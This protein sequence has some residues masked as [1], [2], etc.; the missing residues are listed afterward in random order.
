MKR[1]PVSAPEYNKRCAPPAAVFVAFHWIEC[2]PAASVT[3]TVADSELVPPALC[4]TTALPS[5]YSVT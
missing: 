5:M 1:D 4:D 2:S 3:L